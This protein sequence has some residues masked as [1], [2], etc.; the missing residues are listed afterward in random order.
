MLVIYN[1][2]HFEVHSQLEKFLA[3]NINRELGVSTKYI[4][5]DWEEW[6][7]SGNM[8]GNAI[9]D[10]EVHDHASRAL[11]RKLNEEETRKI[12]DNCLKIRRNYFPQNQKETLTTSQLV[13]K[14]K[15]SLNIIRNAKWRERRAI[16]KALD[17]EKDKLLDRRITSS[18]CT[19]LR[20]STLVEIAEEISDAEELEKSL[21]A[22]LKLYLTG[23]LTGR[24]LIREYGSDLILLCFNGRF[25]PQNGIKD[26]LIS[27]NISILMHERGYLRGSF[28]ISK[29]HDPGNP[30]ASY[31]HWLKDKSIFKEIKEQ[32][33]RA[34]KQ[35]FRARKERKEINGF[36]FKGNKQTTLNKR[37]KLLGGYI[38]I[39]TSSSDEISCYDISCTFEM[40][41]DL[42]REL[43]ELAH[44]EGL[45]VVV[46]QHPNLGKIGRPKR[47]SNF[48]K[49]TNW[50][51]NNWSTTLR[52]YEPEDDLDSYQ[53]ADNARLIFSPQSSIYMELAYDNKPVVQI[54]ESPYSDLA[55]AKLSLKKLKECSILEIERHMEEQKSH[56]KTIE[57]IAALHMIKSSLTFKECEINEGFKAK[58]NE[59]KID[60]EDL[61]RIK[62]LFEMAKTQSFGYLLKNQ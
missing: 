19:R 57:N 11:S 3:I 31:K 53:L 40:Q 14:E 7:I 22:A 29:G 15:H 47:A 41:L 36:K 9:S 50:I 32:D 26:E 54:K 55:E 8:Q 30:F 61:N 4:Y 24:S 10:C 33:K 6:I 17:I 1:G 13:H 38:L 46:R 20:A 59:N 48:L 58:M 28:V 62:N 44:R 23:R 56:I 34:L 60:T 5:C 21:D 43:T 45:E 27:R 12:C 16:F 37:K 52:I 51:K 42:I 35:Y 18:L 2:L 49:K 25:N 39:Y